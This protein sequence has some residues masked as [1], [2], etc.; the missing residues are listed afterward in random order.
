[1]QP[2]TASI[3]TIDGAS[4]TGNVCLRA[5]SEHGIQRPGIELFCADDMVEGHG[6]RIAILNSVGA[7]S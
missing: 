2:A 5:R 3:R 6:F 7:M 4:L 1:M